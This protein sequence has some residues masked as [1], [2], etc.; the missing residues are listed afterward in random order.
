MPSTRC[1][2]REASGAR[3]PRSAGSSSQALVLPCTTGDQ[4]GRAGSSPARTTLSITRG[5]TARRTVGKTLAGTLP[6]HREPYRSRR[7]RSTSLSVAATVPSGG[8]PTL[9]AL[10]TGGEL[11]L[12][13]EA[14]SLKAPGLLYNGQITPNQSL[15]PSANARSTPPSAATAH[16]LNQRAASLTINVGSFSHVCRLQI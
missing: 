2:T 9:L 11:G 7:V 12:R 14:N 16:M 1:I 3:G 5:T 6:P 8:S 13:L 4:P 15:A 10:P